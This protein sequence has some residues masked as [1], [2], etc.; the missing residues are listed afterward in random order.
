[1]MERRRQS[2]SGVDTLTK[3]ARRKTMSGGGIVKAR[4]KESKK[5]RRRSVSVI[6]DRVYIPGSPVTT[7]P[8]LLKEAEA[9]MVTGTPVKVGIRDPFKT[10]LPQFAY[11]V[12]FNLGGEQR[13]WT[14]E[15][16][17]QLDACFTD[18]RLEVGHRLQVNEGLAP[19]DRVRV[20][21]VVQRF[22]LLMG[23]E[24]VVHSLGDE[25]SRCLLSYALRSWD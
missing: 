19:I 16:W 3:M 18:E 7:L 6:G 11:P 12:L 23:G 4:D 9:E 1:M 8:E 20:E 14:R 21:D 2:Y 17:K 5:E 15:D 24:E 22:M 13:L 10:P 25:W